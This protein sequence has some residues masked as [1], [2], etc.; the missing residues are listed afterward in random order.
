MRR[1]RDQNDVTVGVSGE[2]G[3]KLVALM[4]MGTPLSAPCACVGLI[5]NDK[6]GT[7]PQKLI[8]AAVGFDEVK[9]DDD[10]GMVLEQGLSQWQTTFQPGCR[11]GSTNSASMLN[12]SRSS[13]CHC[14]AN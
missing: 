7:R 14:S 10:E 5:D 12:L 9:G 3:N 13:R 11:A 8:A 2:A 1:G 4:P 6:F